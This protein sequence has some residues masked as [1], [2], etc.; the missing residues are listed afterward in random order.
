MGKRGRKSVVAAAID[1]LL[2]E[3]GRTVSEIADLVLG[4]L[5]GVTTKDGEEYK[6]SAIVNNVR[7]R[8]IQLQKQ[9]Y[10]LIKDE[11]KRLTF[12]KAVTA[13]PTVGE[14]MVRKSDKEIT[15]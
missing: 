15:R 3:G 1:P 5:K 9:G 8:M 11:G 14:T 10:S 6:K 13:A 7:Q 4:T 12:T 2:L